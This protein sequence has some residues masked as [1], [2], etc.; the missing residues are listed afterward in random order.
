[1]VKVAEIMITK[2]R[3]TEKKLIDVDLRGEKVKIKYPDGR[4]ERLS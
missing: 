1:V 3:I 2:R 4:S